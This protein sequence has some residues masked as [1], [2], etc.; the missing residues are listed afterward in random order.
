MVIKALNFRSSGPGL[1]LAG[2]IVLCSWL[3][4]VVEMGTSKF[5][6]F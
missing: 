1:T 4:L 3:H 2:D 6:A 5:N